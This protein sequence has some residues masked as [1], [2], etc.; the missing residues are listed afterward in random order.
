MNERELWI[1]KMILDCCLREWNTPRG[2]NNWDR[3]CKFAESQPE[4]KWT[5]DILLSFK[6]LGLWGTFYYNLKSKVSEDELEEAF[7][8]VRQRYTERRKSYIEPWAA[9][10]EHRKNLDIRKENNTEEVWQALTEYG[11]VKFILLKSVDIRQL[12]AYPQIE[13]LDFSSVGEIK[14]L[15]LLEQM[16]NLRALYFFGVRKFTSD[17]ERLSLKLEVFHCDHA[18]IAKSVIHNTGILRMFL[19]HLDTVLDLESI[20]SLETVQVLLLDSITKVLHPEELLRAQKL[21]QLRLFVVRPGEDW[22]VLKQLPLLQELEINVV[23]ALQEQLCDILLSHSCGAL[24]FKNNELT[25]TSLQFMEMVQ[26]ISLYEHKTVKG[27]TFCVFGDFTDQLNGKHNVDLEQMVRQKLKQ[28]KDKTKY[29]FDCEV[30]M[31]SVDAPTVEDA[32]RIMG[33]LSELLHSK[34]V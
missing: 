10:Q 21:Q 27:I 15:H 17:K 22:S 4:V 1:D 12:L 6:R 19:D 11:S 2:G 20:G 29:L 33:I 8:E 24:G 23:P 26:D 18:G 28:Q 25:T 16:P 31:F 3:I 32:R 30:G 5:E 34:S 13:S 9:S 14:N 7:R